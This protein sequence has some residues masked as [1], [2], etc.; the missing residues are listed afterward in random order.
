MCVCVC[1][2]VSI[3]INVVSS[4]DW[5]AL[6]IFWRTRTGRSLNKENIESTVRCRRSEKERIV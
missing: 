5:F 3:C 2:S 6:I 4:E 1:V